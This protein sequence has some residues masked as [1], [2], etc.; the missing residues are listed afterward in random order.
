M[1]LPEGNRVKTKAIESF[2][3]LIKAFSPLVANALEQQKNP[4][5]IRACETMM[6]ESPFSS[7]ETAI[8]F[9][10]GI[11]LC[12]HEFTSMNDMATTAFK[13]S[14]NEHLHAVM[15]DIPVDDVG[16]RMFVVQKTFTIAMNTTMAVIGAWVIDHPE[17]AAQL[18][19]GSNEAG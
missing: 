3:E 16:F 10:C 4:D 11:Q 17:R 1:I 14:D 5:Y 12:V 7:W 15:D 6:D 9:V 2:E 13:L 19:V 18:I 8:L